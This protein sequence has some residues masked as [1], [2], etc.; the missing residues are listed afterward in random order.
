MQGFKFVAKFPPGRRETHQGTDAGSGEGDC[1]VT[2]SH[3]MKVEQFAVDINGRQG[4]CERR[5]RGE[6]VWGWGGYLTP[7]V[8][9]TD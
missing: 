6:G 4:L 7:E 9:M 1:E 3:R 2:N 8:R 5:E